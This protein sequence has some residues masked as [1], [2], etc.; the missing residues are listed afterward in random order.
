VKQ[1]APGLPCS[2]RPKPDEGRDRLRRMPPGWDRLPHRVL[3][4]L[5]SAGLIRLLNARRQRG[6]RPAV[7]IHV[8]KTAGTAILDCFDVCACPS[9]E[10]LR[11]C[12]PFRGYLSVGHMHYPTLLSEGYI[13]PEY[14]A[15]A[16][17]FAFV[18]NSWSRVV[19]LFHY[20]KGKPWGI[21]QDCEFSSFVRLVAETPI[22]APG[23]FNVS[24]LSQCGSQLDWL[25]DAEGQE[26]VDY[27]GT[28]DMLDSAVA[29]IAGALGTE[30]RRLPVKRKGDYDGRYREWHTAESRRLVAR[31]YAEEIDRF[32]FRF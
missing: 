24:G 23:L 1:A 29:I 5:E 32:G 20:L 7:F 12:A 18:R 10:A 19:S 3:R 22:P 21:P 15:K 4:L 25:R 28:Y 2:A 27:V 31:V 26:F 8:P 16:F 17:T 14:A 30:V 11:G 6:R 13:E 9:L